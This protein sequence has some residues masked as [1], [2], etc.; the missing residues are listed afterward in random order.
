MQQA[1]ETDAVERN[2][3]LLS[4]VGTNGFVF[5]I[6]P[7]EIITVRIVGQPEVDATP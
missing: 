3:K 4:L 2:K 5:T 6:D 1:W 7:H